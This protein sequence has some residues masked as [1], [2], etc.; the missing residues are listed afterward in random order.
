MHGEEKSLHETPIA[1]EGL[2]RA[3]Y[4]HNAEGNCGRCS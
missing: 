1:T 3:Y 2:L 4:C